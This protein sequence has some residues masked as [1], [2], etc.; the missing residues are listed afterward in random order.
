MMLG[1]I[2]NLYVDRRIKID[3]GERHQNSIGY[4][5]LRYVRKKFSI[6]LFL[7]VFGLMMYLIP[8]FFMYLYVSDDE[9]WSLVNQIIMGILGP[10][11]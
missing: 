4:T 10:F 2:F 11:F 9:D 5:I 1:F 3:R 6:S 7:F 8:G